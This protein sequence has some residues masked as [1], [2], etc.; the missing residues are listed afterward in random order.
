MPDERRTNKR[1]PFVNEVEVIGIGTRRCSDLSTGGIYL[2]TTSFFPEG[3]LLT[4]R[5]KLHRSDERPIEVKAR[6]LYGMPGLGI[7]LAFIDLSPEN[8]ER[9]QKFIEQT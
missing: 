4:I 8:L 6:A 7:G 2:D 3:T 9:I 1:I 5:F